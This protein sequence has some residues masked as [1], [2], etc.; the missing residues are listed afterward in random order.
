MMRK[1]PEMVLLGTTVVVYFAVR[2]YW[3]FLFKVFNCTFYI[4][5]FISEFLCSLFDYIFNV[6]FAVLFCSLN[7]EFTNKQHINQASEKA[8]G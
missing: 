7:G 2:C 4:I 6:F 1:I 5:P 8:A 3:K